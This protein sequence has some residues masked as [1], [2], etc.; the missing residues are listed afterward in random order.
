L[1]IADGRLR[2]AESWLLMSRQDEN[3]QFMQWIIPACGEFTI[4][5]CRKSAHQLIGP[6]IHRRGTELVLDGPMIRWSDGPITRL[7]TMY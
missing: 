6:S 4:A 1:P 5:D 2:K 7:S 3:A